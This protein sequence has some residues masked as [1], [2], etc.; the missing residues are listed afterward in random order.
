MPPDASQLFT[1]VSLGVALV[2]I[3]EQPVEAR[4][5]K[6][7]EVEVAPRKEYTDPDGVTRSYP[8]WTDY[9][10]STAGENRND[11]WLETGQMVLKHYRA[12][13][14]VLAMHDNRSWP[15]GTGQ[16][17]LVGTG[18]DAVLYMRVHWDLEDYEVRRIAGKVDRKVLRAG[19]IGAMPGKGS[20]WRS[21]LDPSHKAYKEN[22]W[23]RYVAHPVL[24]EFSIVP[25]PGDR[26]AR[27]VS[28]SANDPTPS[29]PPTPTTNE[30]P[31]MNYKLLLL[32]VLALPDESTDEEIQA[33]SDALTDTLTQANATEAA[34]RAALQLDA[35]AD[36]PADVA[37]QLAA[38]VDKAGLLTLAEAT[39]MVNE[40]IAAT[41]PQ[42]N[43]KADALAAVEQAV[44][45]GKILPVLHDRWKLSAESDPENTI[46]MLGG[47]KAGAAV[48]VKPAPIAGLPQT[49]A[50]GALTL[51]AA[52]KAEA[53]RLGI[54]HDDYLA[55]KRDNPLI[56][57]A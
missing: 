57:E 50:G 42:R 5:G 46:A 55:A 41:A 56:K 28:Q 38:A 31:S 3:E 37:E 18:D 52:E 4:A 22:S 9:I 30:G 39:E 20:D 34:V 29:A 13:P 45:D 12:N 21:R 23:G 32:S 26:T 51:S 11:D 10:A 2:D 47:L 25:L 19:S 49:P 6:I 48:P 36:L 40:A 17:R 16:P 7:G 24:E 54:S 33:A 8:V 43:L 1:P 14:V 15:V 44:K 27:A 35:D 53:D